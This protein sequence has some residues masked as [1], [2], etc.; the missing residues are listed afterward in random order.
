M[1]HLG[2]TYTDVLFPHL[3]PAFTDVLFYHLRFTFTGVSL[4]DLE[5]TFSG[6]SSTYVGYASSIESLVHQHLNKSS[7]VG[8]VLKLYT[9]LEIL[10]S[11]SE[12]YQIIESFKV[13]N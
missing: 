6:V 8:N 13:Y 2:P 9:L 1:A 10:S 3:G 4:T 5:Y 7:Y 11:I 12:V